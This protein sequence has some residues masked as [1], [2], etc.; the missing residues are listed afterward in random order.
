MFFGCS[1]DKDQN[2][3]I[4]LAQRPDQQQLMFDS[5]GIM[6]DLLEST[7]RALVDFRDQHQIEMVIVVLPSLDQQYTIS[8][9]AAMLFS[10][11]QIGR[12]I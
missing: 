1:T 7:T 3:E 12:E 11:W 2:L 10:R 6:D 4:L 5:V 8:E 9:A